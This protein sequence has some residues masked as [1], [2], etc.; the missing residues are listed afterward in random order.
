[1]LKRSVVIARILVDCGCVRWSDPFDGVVGSPNLR[2]S[3][4]TIASKGSMWVGGKIE[5]IVNS[6]C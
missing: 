2:Y 4:S 1:M 3:A 5:A 6:Y